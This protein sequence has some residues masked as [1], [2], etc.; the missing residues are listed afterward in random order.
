MNITINVKE[1]AN[2]IEKVYVNF[3][4]PNQTHCNQIKSNLMYAI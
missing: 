3:N 1:R 4:Q 2:K